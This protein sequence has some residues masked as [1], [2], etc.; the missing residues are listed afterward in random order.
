PNAT[1]TVYGPGGTTVL[2][3]GTV[4]PDGNYSVTVPAQINGEELSVTL[5]DA[6]GN[7]SLPTPTTAPDLTP[8][9]APTADIDDASGTVVS[10]IGEP[11]ASVTV[12]GADGAAV[13]GTGTARPDGEYSVTMPPQTNRDDLT[14]TRTDTAGNES[15][16]ASTNA[17]A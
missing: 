8:P 13:L 17:P 15:S 14:G 11:N 6:A 2:G 7:E 5:T 9:A 4:Q 1:V 16:T 10:G 12:C 3:T